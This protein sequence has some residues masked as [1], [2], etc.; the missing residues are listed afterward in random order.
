VDRQGIVYYSRYLEYVDVA[1]TEYFRA[2]GYE[3]QELVT[4]HGLD[5][6]V[7]QATLEYRRPAR[8]DDALHVH[9]RVAAIGHTSF[10]MDYEIARVQG[11][12]PIASAQIVYVNFDIATQTSRPIPQSIR[13]RIESFEGAAYPGFD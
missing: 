11:A 12:E 4:R 1:H 2:A 8:F 3:Y 13:Q 5:P 6:S 10:R 9:A 7:V